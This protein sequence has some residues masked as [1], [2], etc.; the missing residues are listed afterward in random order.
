MLKALFLKKINKFMLNRAQNLKF[1]NTEKLRISGL[2]PTKQRLAICKVLFD[3]KETFHFTI[4]ELQK[5]IKKEG[6]KNVSLATLYDTVNSFKEKGYLREISLKGNST[7]FDT[8]IKK[9]HHFFDE[10]TSKL[11]DIKNE[12]ISI[13]NL[14]KVPAGKKIKDVE[15]TIRV[16]TNNQKQKNN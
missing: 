2:R 4:E 1:K 15:I 8:N 14:P 10:N 12:N 3:R 16:A 5:I 6:I 13:N 9:H 11:I 7:F